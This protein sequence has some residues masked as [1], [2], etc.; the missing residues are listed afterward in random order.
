MTR[1][2]RPK[3]QHQASRF[4]FSFDAL[5]RLDRLTI[6]RGVF[7]VFAIVITTRLFWYQ[8]VKHSFFTAWASDQHDLEQQLIPDRGEIYAKDQFSPSGLSLVATNQTLHLVYVN[9]KQVADAHADVEA[10]TEAIT[11]ILGLNAD[12]VRS[13]VSKEGAQY[14]PLKHEVSDPEIEALQKLVDDKKITGI[15]WSQENSRWYADGPLTSAITG[16]VGYVDDKKTGEYGLEGYF[17]KELSGTVGSLSAQLDASGR[18]IAVGDKSVVEA[19]DGDTLILTI[20][21]NIQYKACTLLA[22]KVKEQNSKQGSLII[23]NPKTG[24]I[25]AMCNAPEYDPNNYNE[26]EDISVYINDSIADQYE[27]GSV[28]KPL[29]MAAAINEGTVTP[30]TTYEDKGFVE[31]AGFTIHNSTDQVHGVVDMTYVLEQSLNTGAIFAVESIGS[32]RWANYVHAFGF[33]EE[34]GIELNGETTGTIAMVDHDAGLS[35]E[36]AIYTATSSYGQ[37]LTVTPIQMLQAYGA[38]ANDGKMMQPYIVDQIVKSNGYQEI[39]E[40]VEVG[41]PI[42]AE[43]ART[44]AAMLVRV[45]DEGHS[46][47]AAVDGYFMAGKTGTAQ[48]PK[49]NGVGYDANRHKDTYMGFGPVSD[50][51]FVMLVKIDEPQGVAFAEGSVV[52][53]A[54]ELSQYLLNY[55]KVPPDRSE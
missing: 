50:P 23:M 25:M 47:K 7:I 19:Q 31:I 46:K 22:N 30:Y 48:I 2:P 13:R 32:E 35:N 1:R 52:P 16:F 6:L 8:V 40:P 11:P 4:R 14:V 12:V 55:L 10:I 3:R 53:I 26:V 49:E 24:A 27:P 9:P 39:H 36:K 5:N 28:F 37:G 33:G 15:H 41:Q 54:G 21:K 29:T 18:Y 38:L 44:V 17:N 34:T 43:T 45:V 42:S 20:D 51:Q